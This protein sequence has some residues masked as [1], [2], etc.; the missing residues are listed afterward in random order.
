MAEDGLSVFQ[1]ESLPNIVGGSVTQLMRNPAIDAG[2]L[3]CSGDRS[4]IS[5]SRDLEQRRIR[6][7]GK[8]FRQ[9]QL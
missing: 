2:L 5:G 1:T 9:D 8:V 7:G 3:T 4:A 6:I